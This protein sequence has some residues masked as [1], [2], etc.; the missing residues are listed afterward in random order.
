MPKYHYEGKDYDQKV[1]QGTLVA[2]SPQDVYEQL[3]AKG[4]VVYAINEIEEEKEKLYKMKP[5]E[6]SDF[7]RYIGSMQLSGV[8]MMRAIAIMKDRE[9][10]KRIRQ[11]YEELYGI[12]NQGNSLGTAMEQ[13]KEAFP[14][15]LIN[16]YKAGEVSGKLDQVAM[17]MAEYY[18]KEHKLNTKIKNAM[19]YPLIL[20]VMIV[21]VMIGMFTMILPRFF[22]LFE[23][24]ELPLITKVIMAISNG[25]INHWTMIS[26]GGLMIGFIMY[27]LSKQPKVVRHLDRMKLSIYKIGYLVSIIYTARFTRTLS[28]LYIS[29]LSMIECV[30]VSARTIGN[31]HIEEQFISAIARIKAGTSLSEAMDTVEGL[32]K[33]MLVAIYIGEESGRLD[34]M[35]VA[36]ADQFEYEANSAIKKLITLLEPMMIIIVG[37][38]IGFLMLGV[39]LPLLTVYSSIGA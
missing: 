10:N 34:E 32:D 12:I 16:M 31:V 38:L 36:V 1:S 17:K 5:M 4:I 28:S 26:G 23:G 14:S 25:F 33:K 21:V 15:L 24:I 37:A 39:M 18:E 2:K 11:V 30:T 19:M 9:T 3:K 20:L 27:Y 7:S 35:L 13:C 6:L 29:G 22:T 8:G